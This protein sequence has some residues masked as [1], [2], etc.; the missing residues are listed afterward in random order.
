LWRAFG[1]LIDN[2]K[3]LRGCPNC[4]QNYAQNYALMA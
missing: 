3:P 4:A 1:V 2:S